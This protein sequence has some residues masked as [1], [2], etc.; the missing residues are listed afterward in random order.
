M[1]G[2]WCPPFPGWGP[3]AQGSRNPA[4][5]PKQNQKGPRGPFGSR[6]TG[7]HREKGGA[8]CRAPQVPQEEGEGSK[9]LTQG[10]RVSMPSVQPAA[11]FAA[12]P[13]W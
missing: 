1:Q 8:A 5:S 9:A 11:H 4:P 13:G 6:E 2:T 10:P 3:K 12:W 7:Q